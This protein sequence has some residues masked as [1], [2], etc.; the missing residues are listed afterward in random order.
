VEASY[1]LGA[2]LILTIFPA[3]MVVLGSILWGATEL[4]RR[5]GLNRR[6]AAAAGWSTGALLP[7][8][9]LVIVD[10]GIRPVYNA[11]QGSFVAESM[12][13]AAPDWL[14]GLIIGS[15]ASVPV[16]AWAAVAAARE[17]RGEAH[18]AWD[19]AVAMSSALAGILAM[20]ISVVTYTLVAH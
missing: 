2:F 5:Q 15:F 13:L 4:M 7:S 16:L 19:R 10:Q 3:T 6:V 14:L 1:A 8:G 11:V 18:T 20:P 12:S 9:I 17:G